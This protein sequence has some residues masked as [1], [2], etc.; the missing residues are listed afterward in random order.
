M[1]AGHRRTVVLALGSNLGDR[2]ANLQAG[3]DALCAEP[4]LE[5]VAVSPVY[6]TAPIGGPAQP[7][8]LNAVLV[9]ATAL[10]AREVLDRGQAAECALHRVRGQRWGPRTLDV[11]VIACGDEVSDDPELTLPHPRA[12]QRA[13]VLAPWHDLEPDAVIPGRGRVAD[14]LAFLGTD[15]VRLRPDATLRPPS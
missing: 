11:D 14:L 6:E 1:T 15:G 5:Q 2:L 8:Y 4:G 13:F 10:A 7:D 3:V 9:A 12:H